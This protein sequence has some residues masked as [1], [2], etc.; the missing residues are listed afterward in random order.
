MSTNN[1][2]KT[3]DFSLDNQLFQAY[4]RRRY[5]GQYTTVPKATYSENLASLVQAFEKAI[6]VTSDDAVVV[7]ASEGYA[8]RIAGPKIYTKDGDLVIKYGKELAPITYDGESFQVGGNDCSI[9]LS[10][11][12]PQLMIPIGKGLKALVPFRTVYSEEKVLGS[13]IQSAIESG[14]FNYIAEQGSGGGLNFSTLKDIPVGRYAVTNTEVSTGG[15]FGPKTKVTITSEIEITAICSV[16]TTGSWTKEE[17]TIP[18]GNKIVVDANTSLV[19]SLQGLTLTSKD[20]VYL[21]V[22]SKRIDDE[23][24]KTYVTAHFDFSQSET[25]KFDF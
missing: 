3:L 7:V 24:G 25:L 14:D 13:V 1:T 10:G 2:V 20:E 8:Q 9:V 12:N 5:D 11:E 6:G 15:R 17:V 18:A 22:V 23:E 19:R 4:G 16:G 21:D